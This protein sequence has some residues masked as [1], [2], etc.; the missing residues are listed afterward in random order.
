M[1]VQFTYI[2]KR[3]PQQFQLTPVISYRY[4]RKKRKNIS[5]CDENSE[6]LP[7]TTFTCFIAVYLQSPLLL[8]CVV[9]GGSFLSTTALQLHHGQPSLPTSGHHKSDLFFFFQSFLSE[10]NTQVQ[11]RYKNNFYLKFKNHKLQVKTHKYRTSSNP[12]NTMI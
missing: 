1:M 6:D 4:N 3:L 9:T 8:T 10:K 7:S 12:E 2:V 5:S 11:R